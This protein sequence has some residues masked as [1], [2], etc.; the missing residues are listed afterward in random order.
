MKIRSILRMVSLNAL[1][2]AILAVSSVAAPRDATVELLRGLES[3]WPNPDVRVT[4]LGN[5]GGAL[6]IGDEL[7]YQFESGAAGYLTKGHDPETLNAAI[8]RVHSGRKYITPT[9]AE[10]LALLLG[11]EQPAVLHQ[12]LSDREF[13]VMVMLGRGKKNTEI[14]DDLGVSPKTVATYRA[15]IFE[16]MEFGNIADLVRYTADHDLLQ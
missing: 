15:R 12:L 11:P 6:R 13:Q 7:S 14:G 3:S 4:V 8:R 5:D 9:L 10:N 2:L 16:K 1:L